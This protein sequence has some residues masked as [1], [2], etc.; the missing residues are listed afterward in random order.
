MQLGVFLFNNE[1]NAFFIMHEIIST[2][3]FHRCSTATQLYFF[4]FF[5]YTGIGILIWL[6]NI[7]KC[8]F[9]INW[10][11]F[12]YRGNFAVNNK[13]NTSQ[14]CSFYFQKPNVP[15]SCNP[16]HWTNAITA[17]EKKQ[18]HLKRLKAKNGEKIESILEIVRFPL[19]FQLTLSIMALKPVIPIAW[20][21]F[22]SFHSL[23]PFHWNC[24]IDVD[25]PFYLCKKAT[26]T[27]QT[28]RQ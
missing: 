16:L 12:A 26:A 25:S 5:L 14:I 8:R 17:G 10:S 27:E 11:A 21:H 15:I 9:Q 23:L 7:S 22:L 4:A 18:V 28:C 1:S 13:K 19:N 3:R 2:S 24:L 20:Q 6:S